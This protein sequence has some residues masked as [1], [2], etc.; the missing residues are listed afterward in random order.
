MLNMNNG[1]HKLRQ[2]RNNTSSSMSCFGCRVSTASVLGG[3]LMVAVCL[4]VFVVFNSHYTM[5]LSEE[6]LNP[7]ITNRYNMIS[8]LT[9]PSKPIP[10]K[11]AT[12]PLSSSSLRKNTDGIVEAKEEIIRQDV[13]VIVY[14][15]LTYELLS[16]I[17]VFFCYHC[18]A[19]RKERRNRCPGCRLASFDVSTQG[20]RHLLEKP[21]RG[22]FGLS[23]SLFRSF[24]L[25]YREIR[26]L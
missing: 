26:D 7:F 14:H 15:L 12:I 16:V 3:S 2:N 20:T 8:T 22:R 11:T 23:I 17:F 1:S 25:L 4:F 18:M 21:H 6:K 24:F 13:Q 19:V 9:T 10:A 5:T